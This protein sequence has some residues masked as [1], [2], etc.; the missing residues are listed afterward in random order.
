MALHLDYYDEIWRTEEL[1]CACGWRG[2]SAAASSEHFRALCEYSCPVC[3]ASLLL[4]SHPTADDIRSAAARG[5]TE[6][7]GELETLIRVERRHERHER[8][9]L[10]SPEQ[11]PDLVGS[12][13]HFIWE[14]QVGEDGDQVVQ[15]KQGDRVIWSE[16]AFFEDWRRFNQVKELLKQKY[17]Q[18]FASLRPAEGAK[19][20]LFGDDNTA[21]ISYT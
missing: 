9:M 18:H 17:P 7:Q 11:L 5:N 10:K 19:L 1:V 12:E 13:L 8:T 14:L 21:T 3:Y 16:L 6:A 15:L 2:K 20:Y 4:V